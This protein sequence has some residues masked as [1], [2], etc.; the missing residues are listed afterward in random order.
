[1]RFFLF[2]LL[3]PVTLLPTFSIAETELDLANGNLIP[4]PLLQDYVQA[5]RV[6]GLSQVSEIIDSLGNPVSE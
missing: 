1:M 6:P 3:A 4:E 5:N 2:I